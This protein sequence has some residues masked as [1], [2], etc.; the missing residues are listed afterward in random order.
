[1][2]NNTNDHEG[3]TGGYCMMCGRSQEQAGKMMYLPGGLHICQDC[4]QRT[5]D[6]ANQFD[7][8]NI[9]NNPMFRNFPFM[10]FGTPGTGNT[11]DPETNSDTTK[12]SA[13]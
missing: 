6:M 4:M 10:S 3:N 11:A 12:T 5:M 9:Q 7:W 13:V 1:M 8:S 2:A